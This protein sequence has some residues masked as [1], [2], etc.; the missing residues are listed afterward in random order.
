LSA[1]KQPSFSS[2][3]AEKKIF[4]ESAVAVPPHSDAKQIN[5]GTY[6]CFETTPENHPAPRRNR[7]FASNVSK[8]IAMTAF[9]RTW[10]V[11]LDDAGARF[12]RR[13]PSGSLVE[14]VPAL[15]SGLRNGASCKP[16]ERRTERQAFLSAVMATLDAACDKN[17]CDRLLVVAPERMLGAFRR[18]ASDKVR[19]RLWREMAAEMGDASASEVEKRLAPHFHQAAS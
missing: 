9:G 18:S 16:D 4:A 19:A 8:A 7:D 1:D 5:L 13:E 10:I 2:R 15:A 11:V 3:T 12:Y 17:H 14:E 6:A